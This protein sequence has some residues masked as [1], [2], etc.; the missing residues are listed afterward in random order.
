MLSLSPSPPA[1]TRSELLGRKRNLRLSAELEA[2]VDQAAAASGLASS[3]W[4]RRAI[5]N[6]LSQGG[7]EPAGAAGLASAPS[8]GGERRVSLRVPSSELARWESEALEH[9]LNLNRYIRLQMS[10][11]T[12]RGR[13]VAAAVE[14]LG[15]ASVEIARIGRNLNQIARSLNTFPGQTTTIQRGTLMEACKAVATF[16]DQVTDVC[17]ALNLR[18]GVVV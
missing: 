16:A 9:G 3:E 7:K 10:V 12:D 15:T 17:T 18:L 14:V 5:A 13:R 6:G 1:A 8:D 11:T 2:S 4:I